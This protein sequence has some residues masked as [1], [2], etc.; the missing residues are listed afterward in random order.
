MKPP[1]G[2]VL[3]GPNLVSNTPLCLWNIG[4]CLKVLLIRVILALVNDLCLISVVFVV[5]LVLISLRQN[6]LVKEQ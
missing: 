5:I 3:L 4:M 6:V 1:L 2:E